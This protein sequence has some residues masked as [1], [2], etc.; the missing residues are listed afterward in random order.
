LT[1]F[2]SFAE[3]CEKVSSISGSLYKVE[4]IAAFLAV[5]SEEELPISSNLLMGRACSGELGVG[6]SILYE[7]ISRASGVTLD[8]IANSLRKTGD[9]GL[10]AAEAVG[11]RR[12]LTLSAFAGSDTLSIIEVH[13]R[14]KAIGRAKGKGSQNIRAKNL[15]F[16]FSEASPL[17][18]QY[19]ARLAMEDLR[20]GAGEGL[21]RNAVSV[22][23]GRQPQL[24][25]RAYSLTNDLGLVALHAKNGTL[26][27]L[28]VE[29]NRPI[30]M[31]L[32]EI[33]GG[34]ASSLAE[35]ATAI[36]WKFD[37]A[38]VQIHKNG[39][40][41][42]IYSRR[43]EDI[44]LSLPELVKAII[45]SVSA[46]RAI[47]DGEAVAMGENG[48]PRPFQDVLKRLRRKYN[49][50][51]MAGDIPMR[52]YLF[53]LIY[54]DGRGIIDKPLRERRKMLL[55]VALPGMVAEQVESMQPDEVERIYKA[56]LA[57]GHEGI[58]MKNPSSPYVPG[59][60]GKNWLKIKPTLES[61][62]LVVTG[63]K[64][65]EG[66]RASMLGSYRLSAMDQDKNDLCDVGYVAT[67]ISDEQL[68][69]LTALFKELIIAEGIGMDV[70]I[71]P[72]VVFEVGYE[73]IQKSPNYSSGY[74]LRF[75]RL[76]SVREDKSLDD[77]DTLE[78]IMKIYGAQRGRHT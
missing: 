52:L 18:A 46:D 12:R 47:L 34:I 1:S 41:V 50:A 27:G 44:T 31:M 71:R 19:I 39:N 33:G 76:I 69:E 10:A 3:L 70:E 66:R 65:G 22:A 9:P 36:E 35:G 75:P 56:S 49:V 13:E 5:Q 57:A 37:G 32:S 78:R 7:A 53:D 21:L 54:L 64:W 60:R 17:E 43:L 58:M 4:A 72:S 24:V 42:A 63:A 2:K 8:F 59:K 77:V 15:Q 11:R 45:E 28:D 68:V 73:E 6:P 30:K 48:R 61:L 62:D 55:E 26:E 14:F 23:F 20:I 38:R 25:E 51:K 67:G 29:M 16:L 74:A 40:E